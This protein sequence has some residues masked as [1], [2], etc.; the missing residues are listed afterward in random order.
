[1]IEYV[2]IIFFIYLFVINFIT[3]IE[4]FECQ[5][6]YATIRKNNQDIVIEEENKINNMNINT[7]ALNSLDNLQDYIIN[8]IDCSEWPTRK[9]I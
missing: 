3:N 6:P 1:M 9:I 7:T 5:D 2:I 8:S 4:T